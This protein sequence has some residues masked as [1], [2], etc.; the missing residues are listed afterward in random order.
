MKKP[1]NLTLSDEVRQMLD[2]TG[3]RS[4]YAERIVAERA[5]TWS[6]SLAHLRN[7]GWAS[8]EILAVC[9]LLN[10]S[11]IDTPGMAL[12]PALAGEMRDALDEPVKHQIPEARWKELIGLAS[13]EPS[14]RAIL[15]VVA[16]YWSGNAKARRAIE[17]EVYAHA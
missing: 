12:G 11:I 14:A 6:G 17:R 13:Q 15:A 3:N 4:L 2:D 5:R 8:S 7:Q 16:E 10:G 9:D 1:T